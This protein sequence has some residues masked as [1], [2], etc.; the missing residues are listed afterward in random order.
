MSTYS[1]LRH[2]IDSKIYHEETGYYLNYVF[3]TI[4]EPAIKQEANEHCIKQYKLA[5]WPAVVTCFVYFPLHCYGYFTHNSGHPVQLIGSALNIF[6]VT[7]LLV[8][9]KWWPK[10]WF[11]RD[12]SS[13]IIS[14]IFLL[15]HVTTTVCVYYG[16]VPKDWS[17][18]PKE[19]FQ[20][21]IMF[22]FLFVNAAPLQDFKIT[23][24]F[25]APLFLIGMYL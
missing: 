3:L 17:T 20:M 15:V 4:S 11:A 19:P 21:T 23:V 8:L 10:S 16:Y 24:L 6:V 5:S 14:V 12:N 1:K 25:S 2:Y 13:S 22:I 7:T 9:V 18:I